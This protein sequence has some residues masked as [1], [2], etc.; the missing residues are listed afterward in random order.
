ML[1]QK[2]WKE[3]EA[4]KAK[5]WDFRTMDSYRDPSGLCGVMSEGRGAVSFLP[6]AA[7]FLCS[8]EQIKSCFEEGKADAGTELFNSVLYDPFQPQTPKPQLWLVLS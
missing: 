3:V 4:N 8:R 6:L 2:P 7:P 1:P 5:R